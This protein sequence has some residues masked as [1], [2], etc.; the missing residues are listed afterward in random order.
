MQK[1]AKN[2]LNIAI[3]TIVPST[4]AQTTLAQT[5]ASTDIRINSI[6]LEETLVAEVMNGYL[7]V[8]D[9]NTTVSAY[10]G[11]MRL[12]DV[13][14]ARMI[15][16]SHYF[17]CQQPYVGGIEKVMQWEYRANNGSINMGTFS[18]RCTQVEQV[19]KSYGLG[20]AVAMQVRIG[21]ESRKAVSVPVLDIQGEEETN[22]FLNFV[23]TLKPQR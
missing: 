16:L 1:L 2:I 21:D 17:Y 8:P 22:R 12:Y 18:L 19:V 10:G 14:I 23:Q 11:R 6:R 20:R 9:R 4:I 5:S 3:A 7:E 15:A 13:H